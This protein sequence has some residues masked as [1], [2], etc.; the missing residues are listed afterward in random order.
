MKQISYYNI[1][2]D[3][4]NKT[5]HIKAYSLEQAEG[6]GDTIDWNEYEDGERIDVMDDIANYESEN[7]HNK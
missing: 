4:T 6:I 3:A 5:F 1:Y 2:D 7:G